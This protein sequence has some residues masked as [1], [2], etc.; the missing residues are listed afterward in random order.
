[1]FASDWQTILSQAGRRAGSRPNGLWEWRVPRDL[2]VT[3]D[4]ESGGAH[5][6]RTI[7]LSELQLL[8]AA[9]P[10]AENP[11]SFAKAIVDRNVLAKKS[12]STR[13]RSLRYLRELYVLD[14]R[15][16]LFSGL[17]DL[18]SAEADAQPLLALLCA[19]ARD[20]LLRATADTVLNTAMGGH[21]DASMLAAAVAE[22]FPS[23]Y[24]DSIR[25][26]IGRNAASSWT[27]SGHLDGRTR[28]VRARAE[29]RPAAVAYAL[30][31][32]H[33][34]DASGIGLLRTIWGRALDAPVAT[35]FE[36][37]VAASRRGWIEFRQAGDVI[38]VGFSWL[39]RTPRTD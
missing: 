23:S 29:C 15:S 28:K 27:Q 4:G 22:R 8:L 6:S 35:V 12:E 26:K 38:D 7:M 31:I 34:A 21:V 13:M 2:G 30:M 5:T 19:L 11:S 25:N 37:A 36:Q 39:L 33:L 3:G 10:A 14:R 24:S 18:W 1:M 20:P 9:C 17:Q 16:A 32:G